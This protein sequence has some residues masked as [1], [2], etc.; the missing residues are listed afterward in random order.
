MFF[1]WKF[2]LEYPRDLTTHIFRCL[3]PQ[4]GNADSLLEQVLDTSSLLEYFSILVA[5]QSFLN[6][7][8]V[9]I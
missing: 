1:K 8:S 5:D 7:Q 4:E 2:L 9:E 6:T 3:F